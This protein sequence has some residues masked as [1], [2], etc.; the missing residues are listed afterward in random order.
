MLCCQRV[1]LN[2]M[3]SHPSDHVVIIA[4]VF[5][6]SVITQRACI[7]FRIQS[8]VPFMSVKIWI[9]EG[10]FIRL[11]N[12]NLRI[13]FLR[14]ET[15][16]FSF[17]TSDYAFWCLSQGCKELIKASENEL[18]TERGLL[19]QDIWISISTIRFFILI[20]F[21]RIVLIWNKMSIL[22]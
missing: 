18:Q 10:A 3:G 21:P 11:T 12:K 5:L 8:K 22:T 2:T 16:L 19:L 14:G 15:S 20:I 17:L 6:N 9:L 13:Y 7:F 1:P 4:G